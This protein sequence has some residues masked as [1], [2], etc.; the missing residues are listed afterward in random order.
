MYAMITRALVVP[1]INIALL[2]ECGVS[3]P[4][5]YKRGGDYF[6]YLT[7]G[8]IVGL[9]V[10]YFKASLPAPATELRSTSDWHDQCHQASSP[11]TFEVHRPLL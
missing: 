10:V 3:S 4:T 7:P 1:W 11:G 9:I 2:M 6:V 8:E 5:F